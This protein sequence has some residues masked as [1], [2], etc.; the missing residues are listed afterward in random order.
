MN[1]GPVR[2]PLCITSDTTNAN[3]SKMFQKLANLLN[4]RAPWFLAEIGL[5][6]TFHIYLLLHSANIY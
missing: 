6:Q 1:T 4:H 5:I 3:V 2:S